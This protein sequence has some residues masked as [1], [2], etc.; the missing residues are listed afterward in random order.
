M[1]GTPSTQAAGAVVPLPREGGFC[2]CRFII[3][4]LGVLAVVLGVQ[5][6][7]PGDEIMSFPG[8]T[9]PLPSRQVRCPSGFDMVCIFCVLN[10]LLLQF[11]GYL[12]VSSTKHLHYVLVEAEGVAP[13]T[14]PGIH[15][16]SLTGY[17]PWPNVF[18]RF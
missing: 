1:G 6:A 2:P 14:A 9:G 17:R 16:L 3:M 15:N 11:S 10:S 8:W 5:A 18:L 4:L 7:V 13:A 12:D